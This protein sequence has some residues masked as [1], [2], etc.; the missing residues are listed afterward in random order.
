MRR[1]STYLCVSVIFAPTL[2]WGSYNDVGVIVNTN[3]SMSMAIGDY[4]QNARSIPAT[5]MIYISVSTAEEIDSVEFNRLRTQV[6]NHLVVNSLVTTMN[7]LVTTKGVPLKVNR[8]STF[9][10][11]SPSSSVESE[12]A[13]ILGAYSG[14][15]GGEGRITSPYYFQNGAFSKAI[16]DIYLVTRLDGY[17]VEQVFDLIDRS[18]PQTRVP[19]ESRFVLDQDPLWN[20]SLPSLNN[21]L[22]TAHNILLGKGKVAELNAD[23]VF[24][25][26]R[27][28][29]VG[30]VS[31]GS[32]DHFS[33]TYTT[34]A[35]PGHVWVPGSIAETYVSTSARSFQMPPSY[36]QS[37]VAD[38]IQEGVTGVKGYVYEPFSSS[39]A[40]AFV[41]FDRYTAGY[42]LAESF[43]M[44]SRYISWMD[45]I[46][47][48]PKTTINDS[49]EPLPI[50]LHYFQ[51]SVVPN[52]DDVLISW[53]TLSEVQNY[54]FLIQWSDSATCGFVDIP[55]SFVAGNG[56]TIVPQNYSWTHHDVPAGTH[57]YRLRQVD[58]DGT[59]HYS[60]ANVV[61]VE[62][63]SSVTSE[64]MF[65]T[66]GLQQNH[67]N[68]FNPV[69]VIPFQIE[70]A[71][72]VRLQVFD[73][74][75]R[76]VARLVDGEM[77]PGPHTVMFDGS[78]HASAVL[79]I[80]LESGGRVEVKRMLLLK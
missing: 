31:W 33:G 26:N 40:L 15:I 42:N 7:Y 61:T 29:V 18:G 4:F 74:T 17:S 19:P 67:P 16:Y 30:Y 20:T 72:A 32:N 38:L 27:I 50:Q 69:T 44:S 41:L 3:S 62:I 12:L 39:M 75:G 66:F 11:S 78:L 58:F 57:Y 47:G 1:W 24:V 22:T 52:S 63:P 9:S 34:N 8:G 73:I 49:G 51:T 14:F 35:V 37:L 23:S 65:L 55:G 28:D 45:V 80:R 46:V 60:N 70:N 5:N 43:F 21:Y 59:S 36:G 76:E 79:F 56:T 10:T 6:E 53:G 71:G 25:T 2:L 54:G 48:D 64:S 68:P 77:L 13:C